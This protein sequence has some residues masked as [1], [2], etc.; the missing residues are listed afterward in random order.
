MDKIQK[1]IIKYIVKKI[2]SE[3]NLCDRLI[4]EQDF[5]DLQ[6]DELKKQEQ[7]LVE[8]KKD[9]KALKEYL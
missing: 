2:D 4:D 8:L 1:I 5:L 7:N 6:K 9:R 3:I